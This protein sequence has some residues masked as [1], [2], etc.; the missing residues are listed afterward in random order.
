MKWRTAGRLV[1]S[2]AWCHVHGLVITSHFVL[3]CRKK[4][5]IARGPRPSRGY[6]SVHPMKRKGN[7]TTTLV[8]LID[9]SQCAVDVPQ[10]RIHAVIGERVEEFQ[11]LVREGASLNV[12]AF[13]LERLTSLARNDTLLA[14]HSSV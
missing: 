12:I 1:G 9:A 10:R 13:L 14:N 4:R 11:L 5:A 6:G 7:C 3:R 8:T 2:L